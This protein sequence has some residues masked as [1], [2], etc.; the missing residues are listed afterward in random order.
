MP[1]LDEYPVGVEFGI[2]LNALVS[3]QPLSFALAV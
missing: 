3:G 2:L 1:R